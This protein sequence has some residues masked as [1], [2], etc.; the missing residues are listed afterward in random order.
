M[1]ARNALLW[2]A[3]GIAG[4]VVYWWA[5]PR[6]LPFAPRDWQITAREAEA[7]ALERFRDLGEPVARPYVVTTISTDELL[8]Q[9]LHLETS[10]GGRLA[11]RPQTGGA[12]A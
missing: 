2:I 1:R 6:Y 12:H 8:E 3:A 4:V 9:R 10:G 11:A 7:I 5:Y